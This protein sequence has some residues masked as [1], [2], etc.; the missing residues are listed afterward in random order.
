MIGIVTILAWV[1]VAITAPLISPYSP[2]AMQ[3][4]KLEMP[5]AQH[6]LGTDHLGRD[7]LSRLLW[8]SRVVLLLAPTAVI[9]GMIMAAPLGLISGYV[10]GAVDMIIM[11]GCDILLSFPALLVYILIIASVGASATIVVVSVSVG[12]V[13]KL[14][15][16]HSR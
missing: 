7:V 12:A 11:R 14:P 8:G 16:V 5:S 13:P 9:V 10:G 2:T 4:T 6:W 15:T 1:L 3:A